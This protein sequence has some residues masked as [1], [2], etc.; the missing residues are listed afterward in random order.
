[1]TLGLLEAD[2]VLNKHTTKNK[3]FTYLDSIIILFFPCGYANRLG[4]LLLI[5]GEEI[6]I[7]FSKSKEN[8]WIVL[9]SALM[10]KVNF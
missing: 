2:G 9:P 7:L 5:W 1:M 10:V 3:G 8:V 4:D 6:N